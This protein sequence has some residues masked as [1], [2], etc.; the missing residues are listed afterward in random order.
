VFAERDAEG[1]KEAGWRPPWHPARW[2][3]PS[4]AA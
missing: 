1:R 4:A 2:R 3:G